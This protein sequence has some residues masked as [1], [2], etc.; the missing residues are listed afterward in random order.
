MSDK[1]QEFFIQG[2]TLDGSTFRPSDWAER[3]CGV[4]SCF[5]P[6]NTRD[7]HLYY[8]AY[9]RPIMINRLKCVV[10]SSKLEQIEPAAYKFLMSFARDNELQVAEACVLPEPPVKK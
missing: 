8:S 6:P 7:A 2:V 1:T 5:R 4:M 9:V 10:V 3:L